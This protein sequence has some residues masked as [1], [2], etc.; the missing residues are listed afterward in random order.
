MIKSLLILFVLT[1]PAMIYA[2][3]DGSTEIEVKSEITKDSLDFNSHTNPYIG[4]QFIR[5]TYE[6][7]KKPHNKDEWGD[8]KFFVFEVASDITEHGEYKAMPFT[9]ILRDGVE[10]FVAFEVVAS[11]DTKEEVLKYAEENGITD[12][13][14][15]DYSEVPSP[16]EDK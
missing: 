3:Y 7:D 14:L 8:K 9:M 6:P 1:L 12:I 11:F 2:Q 10:Y 5:Y 16:D 15:T 13:D 4:E